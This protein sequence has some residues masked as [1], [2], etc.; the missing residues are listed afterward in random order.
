MLPVSRKR[1]ASTLVIG[2]AKTGTTALAHLLQLE[3]GAAVCHM[4]PKG[5]REILDVVPAGGVF[6]TKI[7]F[8]HFKG[9]QRHLSAILHNELYVEFDKVVFIRRDLRDEMVSRLLFLSKIVANAD[10]PESSW[11]DWHRALRQKEEDP[12]SLSFHA[13]CDRFQS[14]FGP[15]AWRDI[16][17]VHTDTEVRFN[18]FVTDAIERDHVVFAYEDMIDHEFGALEEYMGWPFTNSLEDIELGRF[19]YTKRSADYGAWREMFLESDC[20]EI[21]EILSEKG[22]DSFDDWTLQ[23]APELDRRHY[24]DYVARMS[25]LP[26]AVFGLRRSWKTDG[27]ARKWQ[28]LRR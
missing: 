16:T 1:S 6:V 26:P 15:N 24:S 18:A 19:D 4:E 9:R 17:G 21:R 13:L 10:H 7:L 12:S 3:T 27:R 8:E 5:I 14:C 25:G 23:A 20:E 11:K 2:K 22:L 28:L